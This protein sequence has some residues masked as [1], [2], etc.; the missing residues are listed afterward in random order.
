MH[1]YKIQAHL[2]KWLMRRTT[3]SAIRRVGE[4][5][6]SI[7]TEIGNVR[8]E[9]QDRVAVLRTQ[10]SSNHSC[11]IIALS[12][13]MGGMRAGADC[14]SL[15]ISSFFSACIRDAKLDLNVRL[16]DAAYEA[17][18]AV[19]S[20]FHGEGGATLSAVIIDSIQGVASVNVGD[21][22]IYAFKDNLLQQITIDD[23]ISAQFQREGDNSDFHRNELLQFIGVGEGIEPHITTWTTIPEKF[24]LTSDGLHYIEKT[25][26]RMVVNSAG[27]PG[28]IARRL[29]EIAKWC[30]GRDNASLAVVSME[31]SHQFFNENADPD[32]T[33][34]WDPYGELQIVQTDGLERKN[35]DVATSQ[36]R[37]DQRI[38]KKPSPPKRKSKPT[39]KKA[40]V[41]IDKMTTLHRDESERPQLKIDFVDET[42]SVDDRKSS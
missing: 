25:I 22:R 2:H 40:T 19:Y 1:R 14:A 13:G 23:T 5:P 3:N 4:L 6:I 17:N 16:S 18:K 35:N 20:A 8:N 27:E 9:N 21:S 38:E 37:I 32:L 24:L 41:P 39:R 30:G 15:A 12:D 26:V 33:Y 10:I 36:P 31:T 7:G 11:I 28:L 42:D 34:V 29:T